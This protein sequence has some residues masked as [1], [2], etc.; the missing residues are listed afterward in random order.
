MPLIYD[1][2]TSDFQVEIQ[3]D[4]APDLLVVSWQGVEALSE[5]YRYKLCL[6][7]NQQDVDP[8]SIIGQPVCLHIRGV[9]EDRYVHG[10]VSRFTQCV[11]GPR[12]ARYELDI[13]PALWFLSLNEEFR[14]FQDMSV[15]EI[16]TEVLDEVGIAG[17]EWIAWRLSSEP[18]KR[19]FC[20]CYRESTFAFISRLL[21]EEG[22]HYYFEHLAESHVLVFG[23]DPTVHGEVPGGKELPFRAEESR[24]LDSENV[25]E[26]SFDL[27]VRPRQAVLRDFNFERPLDDLESQFDGEGEQEHQGHPATNDIEVF[28]FP[29]GFGEVGAGDR[30]AKILQQ[31]LRTTRR[32]CWGSTSC[33]RLAPGFVFSL[34]EHVTDTLNDEYLLT[35]VEQQG[36]QPAVLGAEASGGGQVTFQA[37]FWGVP[38]QDPWRPE[39]LF[40]RPRIHG[41]QTALVVGPSNEEVYTDDDG[42]G[43]VKVQFHW[44][45]RGENDENSS[46]WLRVAQSSAGP[47]MGHF[48]LPRVG[49]EVLVEF[50][51]G[52]PDRPLVTGVLYN[53]E[54]TT[55]VDVPADKTRSTIK[56]LSSP[57]GE[58]FNELRFEDKKGEE[59]IFIH[60]EKDLDGRVENDRRELVGNDQHLIVKNDRV[61][62]IENDSSSTVSRHRTAEVGKDDN[63]TVKGK[64]AVEV[65]Q[66]SSLTV[67]GDVI[68]AFK[69]NHSEE[70][71]GDVYVKGMN[72]VVEGAMNVTVKCGGTAIVLDSSGVTVKGATITLDGSMVKI[73]SGPGS[74]PYNAMKGSAVAPAA[75]VAAVEAA[76]DRPGKVPEL[77]T[78]AFKE[79]DPEDVEAAEKTWIEVELVGD[80]DVGIP[81]E[82]FEI[83][84]PDGKTV[85]GT[86]GPDGVA[87]VVGLESGTCQICFTN[88]DQDAWEKI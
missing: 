67:K 62:N 56:T 1:E 26:F 71:A 65:T 29:G 51:E 63:L 7:S 12:L 76:T 37:R 46:C 2:T 31:R 3:S 21:A 87:K 22:I 32:E 45:R 82:P 34:T 23:D 73:A 36:T 55:P 58:G 57:D 19:N 8:A 42:H 70:C 47:G 69:A 25:H 86:T 13:V 88:L 83:T 17:D 20:V 44:D 14:I 81:G 48:F 9:T 52:N 16:V 80:D 27:R 72:L 64:R 60:A 53:G 11:S 15:Q 74:P 38:S 50:L 6:A 68:E 79:P 59:Q 5:T 33:R 18:S 84:T 85:K 75:A 78:Q 40:P 77:K 49:H 54:N 66:S 30:A 41:V 28:H 24:D 4:D 43:R 61:E 10:I 39:S 35:R